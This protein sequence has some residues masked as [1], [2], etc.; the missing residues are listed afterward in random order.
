M[1]KI[2]NTSGLLLSML[3]VACAELQT[4]DVNP[5]PDNVTNATADSEGDYYWSGGQKIYLDTDY[6]QIIVGFDNEEQSKEFVATTVPNTKPLIGKA[7]A[8]IDVR[9]GNIKQ[10][11]A[12][13]KVAKGKI[14]AHKFSD[15]DS[16]FYMTGDIL[17]QPKEDVAV[18]DILAKHEVD[19][20][21]VT[22][23]DIGVVVRLKDWSNL[24]TTANA[25]YE[26]GM[27][28]WCHP[29][30]IAPIERTA[31]DQHFP[32][33]YYLKNTGQTGGTS[34]VDINVEPAWT[35]STGANIRVAV[36]DDGVEDH[37]DL[38][39]RVLNGYT[40]LNP[41]YGNGRPTTQSGLPS[42]LIGHG[43]ACAGIIAA[44]HNTSYVAGIAPD[45][46]IVPVNIFHTWRQ[47]YDQY[48]RLRWYSV[49]SVQNVAAG[50]EYAWN[51][52][53]GNAD[54]ISNSWGYGD[55][56]ANADVITQQINNAVNQ[57]RLRN[58]V[59][60]G[61]VVVFASGNS[62]GN[63]SY[64]ATLQN[65]IA[66][67]AVDKY[68]TVWNYSCRGSE[69]DVV[70]P[71]GDIALRGDVYTLDRMG[72]NGYEPGNYTSRFGGT[73]AACPQVAGIAA[74]ILSAYPNLT[75]AQVADA[76][77]KS[78]SSYPSRNN[79]T[80][81]G[82]VNASTAVLGSISGPTNTTAGTNVTYSIFN[83][84]PQGVAFTGWTVTPSTYNTTGGLNGSNL[85]IK[86]TESGIYTLSANFSHSNGVS[87]A[88][89]EHVSVIPETP[90]IGVGSQ[91]IGD[92]Y[93][94]RPGT[95][96]S[97]YVENPDLDATYEWATNGLV[98]NM[99]LVNIVWQITIP[100][101]NGSGND[102]RAIMCRVYKNGRHS[103]WRTVWLRISSSPQGNSYRENAIDEDD[104]ETTNDTVLESEEFE[105]FDS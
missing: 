24:L 85:A 92:Y 68:G 82:L 76:I 8:V 103:N 80:G 93:L 37:D 60:K 102:T 18:E 13:S 1:Q 11:V 101:G 9:G 21:T 71:S 26:S 19:A 3:F 79:E 30:F 70:A 87:Y 72:S 96:V 44:S 49:E 25:I 55:T 63:V 17:M 84:Q 81:Y 83:T 39:G 5:N 48:G 36:I 105:E 74:L 51:P 78:G 23:T 38:A 22:K 27:V 4:E 16:P 54:V 6:T 56:P 28:D 95:Q 104:E 61:C 66:V 98:I 94:V 33:Q 67:G 35:I 57:G 15:S 50:I 45:V 2:F 46:K 32:Q 12:E 75:Q 69:L 42:G 58:G 47:G 65:V 10:K 100:N 86:F 53:K 20:E 59:R 7:M 89:T 91:M 52:N 40:P 77:I 43:Q 90:I 62:G 73:S 64:P 31:N 14:F 29:D 41:T 34:G 88:V 99:S 97:V